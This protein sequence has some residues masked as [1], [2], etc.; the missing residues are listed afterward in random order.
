[1]Q[2]KLN[3]GGK[4]LAKIGLPYTNPADVTKFSSIHS[5]PPKGP[6]EYPAI[7]E[8][9]YGDGVVI[10]NSAQFESFTPEYVS[11][12]KVFANLINHLIKKDPYFISDANPF[13]DITV[14]EQPENN[15]TLV[16]FVNQQEHY[17]FIPCQNVSAKIKIDDRKIDKVIQ[18][19]TGKEIP[20]ALFKNYAEI[21][22]GNLEI[23]D[24]VIINYKA[25]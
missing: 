3:N 21:N 8:K 18:L 22:I 19:S 4:V 7:V 2:I 11:Q 24:A 14:F 13:V 16:N 15:R 1:M 5:N 20:F 6:I 12:C 9:N 10:W 23:Y 17:P 25:S